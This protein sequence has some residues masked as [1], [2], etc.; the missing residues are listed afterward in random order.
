MALIYVQFF[1]NNEIVANGAVYVAAFGDDPLVNNISVYTDEACTQSIATP[2]TLDDNGF[3]VD[4]TGT[5]VNLYYNNDYSLQILDK[6]AAAVYPEPIDTLVIE[7]A[8]IVRSVVAGDG[9]NVDST[10][11]E[12]PIISADIETIVVPAGSAFKIVDN[13]ITPT[14]GVVFSNLS[15]AIP[16]GDGAVALYMTTNISGVGEY[17]NLMA[18]SIRDPLDPNY[19][20]SALQFS[21]GNNNGAADFSLSVEASGASSFYTSAGIIDIPNRPIYADNAAAI[22]GGLVAGQEYK[23]ATGELRTVV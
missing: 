11:P 12:N 18:Y 8:G 3:P 13:A 16:I 14:M 22:L 21:A 2:V 19:G 4:S 20:D 1:P 15:T 23:T 6:Y 9:I 17:A 7:Q 5:R 10:D